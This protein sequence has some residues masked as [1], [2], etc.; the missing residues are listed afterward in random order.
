ME[1][2]CRCGPPDVLLSRSKDD[3]TSEAGT[4]AVTAQT[5]VLNSRPSRDY[6]AK[7]VRAF[8]GTTLFFS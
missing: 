3:P 4:L 6:T 1:D 8:A 7:T 5:R 2:A